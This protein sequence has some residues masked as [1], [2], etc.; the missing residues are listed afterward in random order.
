MT[1]IVHNLD[2]PRYAIGVRFED[3]QH[4]PMKGGVFSIHDDDTIEVDDEW[5]NDHPEIFFVIVFGVGDGYE[6]RK[7]GWPRYGERVADAFS[8]LGDAVDELITSVRDAFVSFIE[9][10]KA[11]ING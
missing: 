1:K 8:E 11:K 10:V 4:K 6:D 3:E 5:L 7:F 2:L 9:K